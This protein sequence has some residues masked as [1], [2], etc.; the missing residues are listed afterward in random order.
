MLTSPG[1]PPCDPCLA[2]ATK[3]LDA[4]DGLLAAALRKQHDAGADTGPAD[5]EGGVI[6]AR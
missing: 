6:S 5:M 4:M 1:P 3:L 2:G